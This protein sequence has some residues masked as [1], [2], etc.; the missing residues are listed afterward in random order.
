MYMRH[1]FFLHKKRLLAQ[2]SLR[3]ILGTKNLGEIL[4]DRENISSSMQVGT[5]SLKYTAHSISTPWLQFKYVQYSL[6]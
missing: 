2:T 6:N 3:N 1:P 4:S 5:P